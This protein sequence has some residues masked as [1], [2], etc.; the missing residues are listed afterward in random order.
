MILKKNETDANNEAR[1]LEISKALKNSFIIL[2]HIPINN[3]ISILQ[4]LCL[5]SE[6]EI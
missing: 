6:N 1:P 4:N 2:L 5:M 3:G